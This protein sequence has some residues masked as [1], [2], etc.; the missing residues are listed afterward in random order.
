MSRRRRWIWQ[1]RCDTHYVESMRFSR[2]LSSRT[3]SLFSE[4]T[5]LGQGPSSFL[6]SIVVHG[7]ALGLLSW[8][9]L[10]APQVSNPALNRRY[11]V[12]QIA[13]RQRETPLDATGKSGSRSPNSQRN[14]YPPSFDR[15]RTAAYSAQM[16]MAQLVPGHQTLMQ[17]DFPANLSLP[18]EVPVPAVM[19]WTPKKNPT[20]TIIPPMPEKPTASDVKTSP[21]APN[22]AL[23]L[24]EQSI[25]ASDSSEKLPMPSPST[26]S[27]VTAQGPELM[28]L[29]PAS[30]SDTSAQPT[31]TAVL[32][33]SDLRMRDGTVT[34]P[35]VNETLP[36]ARLLKPDEDSATIVQTPNVGTSSKQ[37]ASNRTER[38]GTADSAVAKKEAAAES[39]QQDGA[40]TGNKSSTS[41]IT[42]PKNGQYE[43][44]VVG[45]SLEDE[46]PEIF[47]L[48][49]GRMAYTV[50][51][52][53]GLTKNWI[54]QYSLPRSEAPTPE[55][56]DAG[57][58]APWPYEIV[59]PRL[60][61]SDFI[62]D[63]IVVHGF[64]NGTGHFESLALVYPVQYQYAGFVLNA[65]QRWLFRPATLNGRA[66]AVEVVLVIPQDGE[67]GK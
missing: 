23:N 34:L 20:R 21:D 39:E 55:A 13:L 54:L 12:R 61:P 27:P 4:P 43:V 25:A 65:L 47:H 66:T 37:D 56:G 62:S 6:V 10:Y 22:E 5:R 46:Y 38:P 51:L 9:V 31:P 14:T 17:P 67:I 36:V 60:A 8:G 16:Q 24:G 32:S 2:T 19:I 41:R 45:D 59:R 53:V 30:T 57:L 58:Q 29:P 11:N 35:P 15:W 64:V 50:Y 48:W 3:T 42:L 1:V 52:P 49:A 26:T 33:L 63:A 7:A 44:V 40:D 18:E 28:Q